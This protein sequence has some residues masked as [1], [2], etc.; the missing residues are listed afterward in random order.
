MMRL[1]AFKNTSSSFHF[2]KPQKWLQIPLKN[3]E[4]V[5]LAQNGLIWAVFEPV[6]SPLSAMEAQILAV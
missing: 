2:K 6:Y 5:N 4:K 1:S 3:A